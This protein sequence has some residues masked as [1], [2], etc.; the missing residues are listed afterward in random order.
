MLPGGGG[1]TSYSLTTEDVALPPALKISYNYG[2][3]PTVVVLTAG[4]GASPSGYTATDP[5]GIE[6]TVLWQP[7]ESPHWAVSFSLRSMG[8]YLL[9]ESGAVT[10]YSSASKSPPNNDPALGGVPVG[11]FNLGPSGESFTKL[12]FDWSVP[13]VPGQGLD[14]DSVSVGY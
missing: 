9:F 8:A 11:A 13:S 12:V 6:I 1:V 2:G 14:I 3:T 4:A 7:Y 5:N 10:G